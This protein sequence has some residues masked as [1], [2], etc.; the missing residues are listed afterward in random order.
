MG[1]YKTVRLPPEEGFTQR[2]LEQGNTIARDFRR[3]RYLAA[4]SDQSILSGLG[5][6]RNV[7]LFTVITGE[8]HFIIRKGD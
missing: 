2:A 8:V 3:G 7:F 5:H 4:N 6:Y 1:N